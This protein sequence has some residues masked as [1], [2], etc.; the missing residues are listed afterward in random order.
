MF[1]KRIKFFF[2]CDC[3]LYRECRF[4]LRSFFFDTLSCFA[5]VGWRVLECSNWVTL[6]ESF[7][8]WNCTERKYLSQFSPDRKVLWMTLDQLSQFL[9]KIYIFDCNKAT[10]L[11]LRG[12]NQLLV[13]SEWG[14][15]RRTSK[16]WWESQSE[17]FRKLHWKY[18]QSFFLK[19]LFPVDFFLHNMPFD[20]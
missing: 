11:L 16:I 3:F 1:R 7:W 2:R 5:R 18:A 19:W 6:D 12:P 4:W 10:C 9:M 8:P 13:P 20:G 17:D 14:K 15:V